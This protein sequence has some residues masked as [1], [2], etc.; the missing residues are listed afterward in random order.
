MNHS[1]LLGKLQAT[2]AM[3]LAGD[4]DQ[5][6]LARILAETQ[7]EAEAAEAE[8]DRTAK[9]WMT[10]AEIEAAKAWTMR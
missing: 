6:H 7:A 1:F 8:V 10:A 3:F 9:A 2:V 5:D 4:V